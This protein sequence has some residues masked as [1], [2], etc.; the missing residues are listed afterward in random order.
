MQSKLLVTLFAAL[1]LTLVKN[2]RSCS[3][4]MEQAQ[5]AAGAAADSA[6]TLQALLLMQPVLPRRHR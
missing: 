5:E 6:A 3:P 2:R 1:V 4:A